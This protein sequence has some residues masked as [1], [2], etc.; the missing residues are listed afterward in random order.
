MKFK[1]PKVS[2]DKETTKQQDQHGTLTVLSYSQKRKKTSYA[3]LNVSKNYH[4]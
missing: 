1:W 4:V 3:V 2:I